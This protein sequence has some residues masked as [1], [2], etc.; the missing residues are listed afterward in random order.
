MTEVTQ[1]LLIKIH[2]HTWHKEWEW[3]IKM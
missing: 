2:L 3:E 1:Y